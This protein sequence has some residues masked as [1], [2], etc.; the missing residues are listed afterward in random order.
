MEKSGIGKNKCLM[1]IE[2][3]QKE[4]DEDTIRH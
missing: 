1:M 4:G 2:L 3:L